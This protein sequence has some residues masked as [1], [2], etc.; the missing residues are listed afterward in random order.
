MSRCNIS[1]SE[2]KWDNLIHTLIS[3]PFP[4]CLH[5]P[6]KKCRKPVR[7]SQKMFWSS[8]PCFQCWRGREKG[9][10]QTFFLFCLTEI[11][12]HSYSFKKKRLRRRQ[13][14]ESWLRVWWRKW[15]PKTGFRESI[16]SLFNQPPGQRFNVACLKI[17]VA[18]FPFLTYFT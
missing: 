14:K 4:C 10:G 18:R 2:V 13:L 16:V 3:L 11:K 8:R 9:L 1:L 5:L 17:L 7:R 12:L 6:A 15:Q